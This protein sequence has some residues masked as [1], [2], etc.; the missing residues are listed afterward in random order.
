[1]LMTRFD[2]RTARRE[3]LAGEGRK[4]PLPGFGD[5]VSVMALRARRPT[6]LGGLQDVWR[7]WPQHLK[8]THHAWRLGSLECLKTEVFAAL[9]DQS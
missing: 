9:R 7:S 8:K 2:L 3:K 1:M 4:D 6:G 5:R